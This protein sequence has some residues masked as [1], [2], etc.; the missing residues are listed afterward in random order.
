MTH[1]ADG[2]R[3]PAHDRCVSG[4]L[5]PVDAALKGPLDRPRPRS[6]RHF[7]ASTPADRP[8]VREARSTPRSSR[9]RCLSLRCSPANR[10]RSCSRRTASVYSP[11]APHVDADLFAAGGACL[12]HVL[13]RPGDAQ[14]LRRGRPHGSSEVRPDARAGDQPRTLLADSPRSTGSDVPRRLGARAP[15]FRRAGRTAATPVAAFE[16]TG[17]RLAG[18][19][20]HPEVLHTEHGRRVR[21]L[22]LE[23]AGCRPP[24]RWSTSSRTR[25]SGSQADRRLRRAICGLSGASTP[26]SPRPRTAR[27]RG[28]SDLRLRDHGLL[29]KGRPSRSSETSSRRPASTCTRGP[30]KRFLDPWRTS[31]TRGEAQDHR[32]EF[33]RV[34]EAAEPTCRGSMRTR[35]EGRLPRPGTLYPDVS[36]RAGGRTSNIKSHHNVAGC[37]TTSVRARRALRTLFRTRSAWSVNSSACLRTSSGATPSRDPAWPFGSSGRSPAAVDILRE[38]DA[39]AREELTRAGLDRDICSSP[40]CCSQTSVLS[41]SGVRPHLRPPDRASTG[42]LRGRDD[43]RLGAGAL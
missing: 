18:V 3:P 14:C 20:W 28:P 9:T 42:D 27:D 6:R 11:G 21:A 29:R 38:A 13:R 31:A 34:F 35:H 41:G 26:R 39:I 40:S 2:S 12:R 36:S 22:L 15:W 32:R 24:G 33:I 10:R 16:N 23:I 7:G 8:R 17:L 19:Q 30:E 1:P 5:G 25:S 37:P 43:R 4:R